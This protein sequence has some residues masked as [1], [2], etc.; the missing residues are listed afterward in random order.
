LANVPMLEDEDSKYDT[1]Y[2]TRDTRRFGHL[3]ED[4][5]RVPRVFALLRGMQC[6][7]V[8]PCGTGASLA[9]AR[10]L[11]RAVLVGAPFLRQPLASSSFICAQGNSMRI[12]DVW[13]DKS[14]ELSLLDTSVGRG[15]PGTHYTAATVKAYDPSGLRSAMTAT[16]AEAYKARLAHMPTHN[17]W[18]AWEKKAGVLEK[19]CAENADHPFLPPVPGMNVYE[20]PPVICGI[21]KHTTW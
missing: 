4:V 20:D 10:L 6:P 9:N 19:L 15:S 17:V 7:L 12:E 16:H 18:Y 1:K 11:S 8:S 2:Y 13:G 21:E 3:D 5:R 14:K